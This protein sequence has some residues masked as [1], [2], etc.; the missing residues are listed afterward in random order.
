MVFLGPC[1]YYL[2]IVII[3]YLLT[4]IPDH[5]YEII[6]YLILTFCILMPTKR[7]GVN[8]LKNI[9]SQNNNPIS[10]CI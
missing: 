6:K 7:K 4:S 5:L 1:I 2:L 10:N 3:L 8:R 9:R